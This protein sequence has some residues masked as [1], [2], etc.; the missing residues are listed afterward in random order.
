MINKRGNAYAA[1][2]VISIIAIMFMA[3]WSVMGGYAK[4]YSIFQDDSEYNAKYLTEQACE[5]HGYWDGTQCDQ[6]PARA[7]S[8]LAK[9]RRVWLVAPFMV[10]LGLILWYWSVTNKNDYQQTG[11]L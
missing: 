1:L 11:G 7:K 2:M 10:V 4:I 9:E 3:Y 5:G 6:L 8:L